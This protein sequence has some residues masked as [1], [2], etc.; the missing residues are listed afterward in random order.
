MAFSNNMIRGFLEMVTKLR[1]LTC[2]IFIWLSSLLFSEYLYSEKKKLA[3]G[4][5]EDK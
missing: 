1:I 5:M 3:L 4:K 2:L